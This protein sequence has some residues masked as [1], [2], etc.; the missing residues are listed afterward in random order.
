MRI[1]R[2]YYILSKLLYFLPVK[3]LYSLAT[4]GGELYYW[5][6]RKHSRNAD[7]TMQ[8]VL[9]EE[10]ANRKVREVARRSFRNYGK[11]MIDFLRQQHTKTGETET[12]CTVGGWKHIYES[13]NRGKGVVL[14]TPHFG[15]WDGAAVVV[16]QGDFSLHSVAKDFEPKELNDLVQGARRSKG[17]KIYS[18]KD[19]LRGLYTALKNNEIVVLLIDSPV[20]GEGVVVDFFGKPARFASGPATLAYRTGA[21]LMFGYVPRQPGNVHTYGVWEPPIEYEMTGNREQDIFNITQAFARA[22]EK[23]VRRH[24]DQWYM[25]RKLW[26][27]EAEFAEHQKSLEL[28]ATRSRKKVLVDR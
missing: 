25:F 10:K 16:M 23:V 6:N 19:A 21:S 8:I 9:G 11:Y 27:D 20:E 3:P 4:I 28:A 13:L 22:M 17:L 7:K 26:L 1:A 2:I 14:V 24:P 5:L 12:F 18:L 15:N